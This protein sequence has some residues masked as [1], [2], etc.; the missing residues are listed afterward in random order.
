MQYL[1]SA[2]RD[3]WTGFDPYDGPGFQSRAVAS[4]GLV[5]YTFAYPPQI[6]PL[7][8]ALAALPLDGARVLMTSLNFVCAV[9]L[10][11]LVVRLLDA[12][13]DGRERGLRA[14][15]V[16]AFALGNPFVTHVVWMGQTSVIASAALAGC[17]L[18]WTRG[19]TLAAGVLL[20]IA[21]IKPQ[22]A[23]L[24]IVWL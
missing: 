17:W 9:V 7:C 2:G 20:G 14:W 13:S 18:A 4:D 11:G 24:P 10:A 5:A 3:W 12:G 6:S 8:L 21:T 1:R 16:A 22:L 23:A 15:A 19:R